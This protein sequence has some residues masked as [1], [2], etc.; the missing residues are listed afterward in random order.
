MKR[1]TKQTLKTILLS[2]LGIGAIVGVASGINALVEKS[3]EELK[4][5][6]PVFEIAEISNSIV[7]E[8]STCSLF[9]LTSN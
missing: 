2:A 1:K 3:D 5:I 9:T 6:H 7:E 4:V 8:T